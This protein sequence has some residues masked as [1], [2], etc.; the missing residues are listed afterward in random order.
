MK[1]RIIGAILA[2]LLA[3]VGAFVLINYVRG[4]DARAAQGAELTEVYVVQKE[5]PRGTLGEAVADYV[6]TDTVPKR[7]VVDEAVTNLDDLN[8]LIADAAILP[9][10]QLSL[11]R[12]VSPQ[13]IGASGDV[14]VPAGMQLLSF[15]LPAD[16]VVGGQVKA[17][18]HIGM[19]STVD[20]DEVGD[21]E[22]VINPITRFAFHT[23]LVTKVQGLT[24]PESDDQSVDQESGANI[25]L[26]IALSAHDAERWVF[27]TEGFDG[28]Y[29][30]MWLTL[31]TP[32]TDN[33]GTAPVT[34]EN[35]W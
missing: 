6:D 17:G 31:E 21:Q 11:A 3:G 13:D 35:A 1:T 33:S 7:N 19:I 28:D 10:E 34:A 15:A 25:M 22:D 9:G 12:F 8:G 4:A 26:T 20:P 29:A 14:P 30:K 27:F 23:V 16:R 24:K 2:L 5:I 18:D 32:E